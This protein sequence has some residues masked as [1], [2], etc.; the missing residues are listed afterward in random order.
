M[1]RTVRRI[2]F[3]SKKKFFKH[4]WEAYSQKEVNRQDYIEVWKYHSDN[5]YT[6]GS[7]N[8]KQAYKKV[9]YGQIRQEFRLKIHRFDINDDKLDVVM[10]SH[11]FYNIVYDLH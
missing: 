3:N 4:Y 5:Y 1:S 2:K 10:E 6:K 11:R 7:K 8:R 9:R